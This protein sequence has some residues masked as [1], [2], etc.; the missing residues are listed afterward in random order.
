[1]LTLTRKVGE[2]IRIGDDIEVVVREIRKNQVRIG[3][4]APREVKVFREE[5]YDNIQAEYHGR[6]AQPWTNKDKALVAITADGRG[7]LLECWG[8]GMRRVCHL[9]KK[10]PWQDGIPLESAPSALE[11][12]MWVWEGV[13]QEVRDEPPRVV[14]RG[15]WR[16]P[17]LA[18]WDCIR[19]GA[20]LWE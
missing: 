13:V 15:D 5:V 8:E 16:R 7:F 10:N 17:T 19:E 9:M 4:V 3:I 20:S 2:Y 18:E 12:G 11:S 1:M 14:S 6:R